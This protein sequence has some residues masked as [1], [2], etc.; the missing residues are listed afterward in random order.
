MPVCISFEE[1][2]RLMP[3][4]R[5]LAALSGA[6]RPPFLGL[7]FFVWVFFLW[8][9]LVHPETAIL[10]GFFADSDDMIHLI[11]AREWLEGQ[12]WFDPV[13]H[14]LAPP[15]GV[16]I[17]YSRL[18]ELPLA[19][20]MAPLHAVGLGWAGASY[21]AAFV[22]PLMLLGFFLFALRWAAAPLVP[23]DWTR[24]SAY[25]A[26]FAVSLMG[27]FSPGRVDHH[28]LAAI[29]VTMAMGCV[30]RLT[31]E[32][33]NPKWPIGGG[34]FL[35]FGLA[36][37]LEVLPWLLLF[38]AFVGFWTMMK[39]RGFALSA[40]LFGLS[41]Y[42]SSVLFLLAAAAPEAFYV[43]SP[44]AYSYLYVMIAGGIALALAAVG[45][46]SLSGKGW[47]RIGV[48]FLGAGGFFAFFLLRFP[49]LAQ[50]PYG[51]IDPALG[52]IMFS[53]ISEAQPLTTKTDSYFSFI[54]MMFFPVLGL[55]ASLR[56]M[57]K[58]EGDEMW[59][60][61]FLSLLSIAALFLTAGYQVRVLLYANLFA[62][63][64]LTELL[65]RGLIAARERFNGRRL[66]AAELAVILLVGPLAG[67]LLPAT[68]DGRSFNTGVL[69]FPVVYKANEGCMPSGLW[70][71]LSLPGLYGDRPRLIMN[72]MNEGAAI[73]F[74]TK[75]SAM[76][77]PYHTNVKGNLGSVH[78]FQATN[79]AEA[80]KI[81][82]KDG[83]ELVLL[84]EDLPNLYQ[85]KSGETRI[86]QDGS[87]QD[88]E[89]MTFAE[90]LI[91][92]RVPDW[93]KR[94]E[95]PFLGKARLFEVQ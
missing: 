17:H 14:R 78:F 29:L 70:Q 23:R 68:A 90:Q 49:E 40:F 48:A 24:A 81:L 57:A 95:M 85:S 1:S 9:H 16:A 67:V 51:G 36:I 72:T 37:G 55:V 91:A 15:D 5:L 53:S 42:V 62:I 56:F 50:G 27:A 31:R 3:R 41:L 32:P 65:R 89:N 69:L 28:G 21:V 75:H 93:L 12:S 54:A 4:S 60:W 82:T 19:A 13:L 38:S 8:C 94:V 73:L 79:P 6:F 88:K 83:A 22:W 30:L 35:A 39:G 47:L 71:I 80:K 92:G 20:I 61:C 84:C 44:L 77:A 66:A 63:L 64:P 86:R 59:K 33:Q 7:A 18:A 45:A 74:H 43:L 10:R 2:I 87:A 58:A 52:K 34:F 26:L 11:R 76:G 25:V 46:A